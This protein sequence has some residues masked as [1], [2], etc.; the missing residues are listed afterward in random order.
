MHLSRSNSHAFVI[1]RSEATKQSRVVEITL[2][3]FAALAMTRG[4]IEGLAYTGVKNGS[5]APSVGLNTTFTF[6]PIFS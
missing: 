3:C 5:G 4:Y 6:W 1:A 2:D